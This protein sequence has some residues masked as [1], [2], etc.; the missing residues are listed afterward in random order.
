MPLTTQQKRALLID[1]GYNPTKYELDED[2]NVFD[3]VPSIEE[4]AHQQGVEQGLEAGKGLK[5]EVRTAANTLKSSAAPGIVGGA[6][7]LG[8][9][10]LLGA[11]PFTG[12]S[13]LIPL[14]GS[15]VAGGLASY[16]TE[17]A[18]EAIKEKIYTPEEI[19]RAKGYS[20]GL[21]SDNKIGA[22]VGNLIPQF[23]TFRPSVNSL[24]QLG[25]AAKNT[26]ALNPV[27]IPQATA[28]KNALVGGS[29][30][31]G[32]NIG[33]QAFRLGTGE[34]TD[35]DPES[36]VQSTLTGGLM[37]EPTQFAKT[38]SGGHL[39][40]TPSPNAFKAKLSKVEGGTLGPNTVRNLDTGNLQNRPAY[41]AWL[42]K[43]N[44]QDAKD[45]AM[46]KQKA[47]EA[48]KTGGEGLT[49]E[50]QKILAENY[51]MAA[52]KL[53]PPLSPLEENSVV[54]AES[55]PKV[56][57]NED[58][59]SQLNAELGQTDDNTPFQPQTPNRNIP[60]E[61]ELRKAQEEGAHFGVDVALANRNITTPSGTEVRGRQKDYGEGQRPGADLSPEHWTSD[62]PYH[63]V[64]HKY[65]S[66]LLGSS[67]K[68]DREM[69]QKALEVIKSSPQAQEF[70]KQ[71]LEQNPHHNLNDA[72]EEYLAQIGGEKFAQIVENEASGKNG[73]KV[74]EYFKTL[75]NNWRSRFGTPTP[76]NMAEYLINRGRS[77][78][79]YDYNTSLNPKWRTKQ[80]GGDKFQPLP[81]VGGRPVFTTSTEKELTN[82]RPFGL[83]PNKQDAFSTQSLV[84][85]LNS[86]V[87]KGEMELLSE[88][89]LDEFL[90][91]K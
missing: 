48:V 13:S 43:K 36:L 91:G 49:P 12:G 15:L 82:Q 63:E 67:D 57:T 76:E 50:E 40:T 59:Q 31:A 56:E 22:T 35:F 73:G 80:G 78:D 39:Q 62:T 47:V 41:E 21:Q 60:R 83:T 33:E 75:A 19:E 18:Q 9:L 8:T 45:L 37:S 85:K 4:Q 68:T 11:A 74:V 84:S 25:G 77:G 64:L 54:S 30:S 32:Q 72:A 69:G 3:V 86:I 58:L 87:P 71:H 44:E 24:K 52:N 10:G 23:A 51:M 46:L 89:G 66:D 16:G 20:E 65:V 61:G 27:T 34:Q 14:V 28:V 38:L 53:T 7:G 2:G 88:N 6:V 42:N 1:H 17:K 79:A 5:G 70:L 55:S 29:I 26:L 90:S 81:I